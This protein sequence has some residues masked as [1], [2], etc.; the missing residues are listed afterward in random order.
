[1][2]PSQVTAKLQQFTNNRD[3]INRIAEFERI[4]EKFNT[5]SRLE[6]NMTNAGSVMTHAGVVA[7]GISELSERP[8][9][10][11][12]G[13]SV[14]HELGRRVVRVSVVPLYRPARWKS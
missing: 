5:L 11:I 8:S 13:Q 6:P 1:M 3:D 2:D 4:Y 14:F 10:N 12:C 9:L 7:R